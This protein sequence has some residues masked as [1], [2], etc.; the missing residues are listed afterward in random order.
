MVIW[1]WTDFMGSMLH[2]PV[3]RDLTDAPTHC[4]CG[5]ASLE[6]PL[7]GLRG[8]LAVEKSSHVMTTD[9]HMRAH[10]HIYQ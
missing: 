2:F 1:V 3:T 10:T 9:K 8:L 4:S 6:S 7:R 5:Q